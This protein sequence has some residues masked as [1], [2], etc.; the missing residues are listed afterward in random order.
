MT[1][2]EFHV[3]KEEAERML[4]NDLACEVSPEDLREWQLANVGMT[5]TDLPYSLRTV[6]LV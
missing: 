2:N 6:S 4:D 1:I 3:G 5:E